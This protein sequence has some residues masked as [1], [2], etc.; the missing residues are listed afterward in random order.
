MTTPA[1]A[2]FLHKRL[3]EAKARAAQGL[4]EAERLLHAVSVPAPD[5]TGLWVLVSECLRGEEH[6]AFYRST[7]SGDVLYDATQ[8]DPECLGD[9]DFRMRADFLACEHTLI[10]AVQRKYTNV[11]ANT[12]LK[13]KVK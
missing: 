8:I 1:T 5:K 12:G 4:P 11:E 2:R 9:E 13:E 6:T 7:T 3:L 10:P